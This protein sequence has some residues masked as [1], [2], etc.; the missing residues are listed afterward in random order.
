MPYIYHLFI[1]II[2]IMTFKTTTIEARELSPRIAAEQAIEQNSHMPTA[3]TDGRVPTFNNMGAM[4]PQID[5]ISEEFIN[6]AIKPGAKVMEIGAGYGLACLTALEKGAQ[7]YTANDMDIRHLQI[8]ART[9]QLK[10]QNHFDYLKLDLGS[11]PRDFL[12]NENHYDAVLV[13]RVLH[14]MSPQELTST[15]TQIYRILKPGGRVYAIMLTPYVK[16]YDKFIPV[17][18]Q[19][20]RDNHPAP[21]YVDNLLAY[22]NLD[23]I[24]A[25]SFKTLDKPFHMFNA[26]TAR[27]S[28]EQNG[29]NI[30]KII[31]IPLP[32]HSQAWQ[33]DGRE[34][35]GVIAVKPL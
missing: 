13:A 35:V 7:D 27:S 14:F 16:G 17:F 15:L 29:F 33:L 28:F 3:D 25:S 26:T 22:A 2:V 5:V 11:F 12:G 9:I 31:E 24:P 18:E 32:Y 21:G 6:V 19:R 4:S 34:N 1:I 10:D 8:L 30:E 23:I 20:I